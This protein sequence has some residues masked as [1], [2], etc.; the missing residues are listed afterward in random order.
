MV[1][2]G[3]AAVETSD[4]IPECLAGDSSHVNIGRHSFNVKRGL[5]GEFSIFAQVLV[6]GG[7]AIAGNNL[8]RLLKMILQIIQQRDKSKRDRLRRLGWNPK[9]PIDLF[10][11]RFRARTIGETI[12]D[13]GTLTGFF[14]GQG[15]L[16]VALDEV[17]PLLQGCIAIRPYME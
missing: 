1:V 4:V 11:S 13:G 5:G 15:D 2:A 16:S 7:T 8:N 12:T 14:V 17:S 6:V 3:T 9:D 10:L